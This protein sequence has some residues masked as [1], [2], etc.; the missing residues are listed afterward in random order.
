MQVE[1][2]SVN[3]TNNKFKKISAYNIDQI[4][5]DSTIKQI[6]VTFEKNRHVSSL[7]DS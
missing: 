4:E 6:K 2:L 7:I 5:I 1:L 3:E